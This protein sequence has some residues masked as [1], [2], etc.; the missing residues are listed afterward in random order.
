MAALKNC[1]EKKLLCPLGSGVAVGGGVGVMVGVLVGV[2]VGAS[3]MVG[4]GVGVMVGVAVGG[5]G[6]AVAVGVRVGR[7]VNVNEGTGVGVSAGVV[8]WVGTTGTAD[9]SARSFA[10]IQ[11]PSANAAQPTKKNSTL[12][13]TANCWDFTAASLQLGR[14]LGQ[15]ADEEVDDFGNHRLV[16]FVS[17]AGKDL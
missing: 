14:R 11:R 2:P 17:R 16:N 6:V 5:R 8:V 13:P 12:N 7:G 15:G 4:A 3:G 10:P 1:D 9:S